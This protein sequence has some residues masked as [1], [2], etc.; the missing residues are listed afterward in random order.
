MKTSQKPLAATGF[1]FDKGNM[2]KVPGSKVKV[3]VL[4][5]ACDWQVLFHLD[6]E[7]SKNSH[8]L[9]EE[10]TQ[11]LASSIPTRDS[12]GEWE[13]ISSRWIYMVYLDKDSDLD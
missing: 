10:F 7:P 6:M 1:K 4:A 2:F 8:K 12:S 3:E 9:F 13:R 11:A 5:Q